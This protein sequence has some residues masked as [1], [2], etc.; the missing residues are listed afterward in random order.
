MTAVP[1]STPPMYEFLRTYSN[2]KFSSTIW[3]RNKPSALLDWPCGFLRPAAAPPIYQTPKYSEPTSKQQRCSCAQKRSQRPQSI[4]TTII[5]ATSGSGTLPKS[6]SQRSSALERP[7]QEDIMPP[8]VKF[9]LGLTA[10]QRYEVEKED[11]S[12]AWYNRREMR[13]SR[14]DT[15]RRVLAYRQL[16]EAGRGGDIAEGED[17]CIHG[18][19][20]LIV[21]ATTR[22]N[23]VSSNLE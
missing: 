3:G 11:V 18:I 12:N 15:L 8:S 16:I 21:S 22:L 2:R 7:L 13:T 14:I 5:M 20:N 9:N 1:A 23:L 10:V 4:L 19:E 6:L 17:H